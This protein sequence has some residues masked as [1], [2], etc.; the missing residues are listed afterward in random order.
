MRR[1]PPPTAFPAARPA[2]ASIRLTSTNIY[3]WLVPGAVYEPPTTPARPPASPLPAITRTATRT[4]STIRCSRPRR[5]GRIR[6]SCRSCSP[7]RRRRPCASPGAASI[8]GNSASRGA[9]PSPSASTRTA[10]S[11][12]QFL[13]RTGDLLTFA[14]T[15]GIM[16]PGHADPSAAGLPLRHRGRR[17]RR[18]ATGRRPA[19]P[20]D[21]SGDARSA[22][23]PVFP[24]LCARR[25]AL[26]AVAVQPVAVDRDGIARPL[27]LR[28]GAGVV[29]GGLRSAAP[30]LHLDR[31]PAT[32][33]AA[34]SGA[35]PGPGRLLRRHRRLLRPGAPSRRGTALSRNPG[36][37]ERRAAPSRQFARGF[38]A[39]LGAARRRRTDPRT[40]AAPGQARAAG[41]AAERRLLY[42]G[43]RLAEP[44]ACRSLRD[45][46]RSP[47]PDPHLPNRP[48][49]AGSA[50]ER[51]GALFRQ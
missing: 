8:T 35:A 1:S 20:A 27:P 19:D 12:L 2:A 28:G 10:R 21:I 42:P 22:R 38:P 49:P 44:S 43:L 41:S 47:G 25:A 13:G 23:L 31:L 33:R 48:A 26:S 14:V 34:G 5:S 11:D 36:R 29:P 32:G 3:F 7:G 18:A 9:R 6:R 16:P 39:G 50:H 30:G 15:N 46:R 40:P 24:V 17:R 45:R 4:I 51:R 37:V